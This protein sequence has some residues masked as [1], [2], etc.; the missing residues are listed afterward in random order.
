MASHFTASE[1]ITDKKPPVAPSSVRPLP[2]E[3][4]DAH[5]T[6]EPEILPP[7]PPAEMEK[8]VVCP[9]QSPAKNTDSVMKHSTVDGARETQKDT[10]A[11]VPSG[12]R[13]RLQRLAEQRNYWES[14]GRCSICLTVNKQTVGVILCKH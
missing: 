1:P 12:M 7:R 11:P 4:R 9:P 2:A 8:R 6:P 5:R 13:S 3:Q 14:E 10:A